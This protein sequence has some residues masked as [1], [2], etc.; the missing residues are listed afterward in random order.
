MFRTFWGE[1]PHG[2]WEA[3]D[4]EDALGGVSE[5]PIPGKQ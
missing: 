1:K 4:R 3:Q 2:E 5:P